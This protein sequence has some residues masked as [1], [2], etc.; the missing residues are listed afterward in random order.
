M[1]PVTQFDKVEKI[2]ASLFLCAIQS[3]AKTSVMFRNLIDVDIDGSTKP[4]LVVG[5]AHPGY[6]DGS[7]I[8]ILNPDKSLI[9]KII[10]GCGYSSFIL[11]ELVQRKCDLTLALCININC[12]Y[13]SVR[14]TEYKCREPSLPKFKLP[15]INWGN[16]G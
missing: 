14:G 16:P 1:K 15:E 11:K 10:P 12:G 6:G 8:A 5:H 4:L 9:S 3:S 2:A 7:C 13:R